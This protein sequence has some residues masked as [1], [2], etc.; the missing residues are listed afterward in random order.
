MG[1]GI[2]LAQDVGANRRRHT[3]TAE[4]EQWKRAFWY[5]KFIHFNYLSFLTLNG[6]DRVL[7]CM[8]RMISAALGRPCAI[9]DEEYV[10]WM[11]PCNLSP[12]YQKSIFFFTPSFDVDLPVNCDDEYWDHPDPE[13]RFKQ[14]ENKPSLTASFLLTI[15]LN[16]ILSYC[17][18]TIACLFIHFTITY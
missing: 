3:L 4:D 2:C 12:P 9:H 17:L 6:V 10:F 5:F 15:K 8:D 7:V 16:Q 1:I 13:Q 11:N 18:R 14:P